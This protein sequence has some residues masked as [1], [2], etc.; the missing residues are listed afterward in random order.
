[1]RLTFKF[2]LVVLLTSGSAF[3]DGLVREPYEGVRPTGM[4][5]AFIALADDANAPWYNPAAL[6]RVKGTHFNLF[7]FTLG[8]DSLGTLGKFNKAIFDG[9]FNNLISANQPTDVRFTFKPTFITK[10]FA[11]SL[12]TNSRGYFNIQDSNI[13]NATAD[14]YAFSDIGLQVSVGLPISDYFSFGATVRGLER[15]AVD[16]H[17]T[18]LDLLASLGGLTEAAFETAAYD[19]LKKMSG[20]GY[21]IA[22]DV[23]ALVSIPT[24]KNGPMV[25]LAA[26]VQDIGQ[27]SFT[28]I[29]GN[30]PPPIKTSYNGGI[31]LIYDAGKNAHFNFAFDLRHNFESIPFAKM[32]HVGLE[33]KHRFFSLRTGL[34]QGYFSY[35]ASF[36]LLPHTKVHFTS[37][38]DELG[39]G[40]HQSAQRYYLMQLSIGFNP[41]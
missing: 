18:T 38:A 13:F 5:N 8:A 21:G 11:L 20:T 39:S 6:A 15:S 26:V 9:D 33:Y 23:G 10:Y 41:L 7:D 19:Q 36:E 37:Y 34:S 27:T 12:Y 40:W 2:L 16:A 22:G 31:A 3:A 14:V 4:G 1:M 35:G 29:G 32:T 28:P 25:Q 17:L 24:G 30:A